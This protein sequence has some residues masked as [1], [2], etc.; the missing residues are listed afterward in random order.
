MPKRNLSSASEGFTEATD[1][2]PS[3]K[4]RNQAK[5]KGR[6][7]ENTSQGPITTPAIS[8]VESTPYISLA[9]PN[10]ANRDSTDDTSD[11][12]TNASTR[13]DEAREQEFEIGFIRTK[14][15]GIRHYDGMI[16]KKEKTVLVREPHNMYDR[17]A[18]RVDNAANEQVG[19][20]PRDVACH[21]SPLIDGGLMRAEGIVIGDRGVYGQALALAVVTTSANQ[22]RIRDAL[23]RSR[24][25]LVSAE[26]L[27][28]QKSAAALAEEEWQRILRQ[29]ESMTPEKSQQVLESLGLTTKDLSKLP[30]AP[31]PPGVVTKLLS[32]QKQ[33]LH[34]MINAEHPSPPHDKV[35]SQFWV[36]KN[37]AANGEHYLNLATGFATKTSPVL[38]RGG[39]LADDMGLGKTLQVISLIL[40]DPTG[41]GVVDVPTPL[42]TS[43]SKATLIVC[44]LSVVGNWTTQIETHVQTGQ[45]ATYVFHG[46][47]RNADPKFLADQDVVV[48]TYNM[49]AQS[50]VTSKKGLHAVK[51]RRVI[52][53]EGHIVRNR[54]SKQSEAA[55]KLDAE[56][57]FVVSGTPIQNSLADLYSIVK[58]LAFNPFDDYDWWNRCFARPV[59]IGD[60]EGIKRL[61]MLMQTICLRRTKNMQF[62]G[63]PIISLPT[64]TTY[65]YKID[66][67]HEDERKTYR[68]FQDE[69]ESRFRRY[70]ERDEV[71]E[72]YACI[73]E[74]LMRMR[75]C[76]NHLSLLGERRA[77]SIEEAK[78][79]ARSAALDLNN[80]NVQRL[81]KVLTENEGE[82]CA[83]C[84]DQLE[85]PVITPCAHFFCR[86]CIEQVIKTKP[87]CP[88]CRRDVPLQSLIEL[89][90]PP[91]PIEDDEDEVMETSEE[92][93]RKPGSSKIEAFLEILQASLHRDPIT[94]AVVFS[95]WTKMLDVVEPFLVDLK[96]PYVRFDGSMNRKKRERHIEE[97]QEN[98][99]CRVF[100]ASLKCA[101]FG[102]NLTAGNQVYLLDPWW[103]PSVEDQ[104][105]DRIYRLGQ[106]RP[107][108]V[109]RIVIRNTIEERVM[110]L[111]EKKRKLARKAFGEKKSTEEVRA[112][113]LEDLRALVGLPPVGKGAV[114]KEGDVKALGVAVEGSG[115][116][117]GPSAPIDLTVDGDVDVDLT[118]E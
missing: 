3:S 95:Q 63:K 82:D 110:Q 116:S 75:Q 20:I 61:K 81:L 28:L 10:A 8:V 57:R 108:S 39:I 69:L 36:K 7:D 74:L 44:P 70:E 85:T 15:V 35:P 106:T 78:Q 115:S 37:T 33:G 21:V 72:N 84:L 100:L 51:W 16:N 58:F 17:W 88:M 111:Q 6:S 118:G 1:T 18:I 62:N 26:D 38:T 112:T 53:D 14:I 30:E 102:L 90:P 55:F 92:V 42:D 24:L 80:E 4:R 50:S 12:S 56:R 5:G 96:I 97:F 22:E 107:V 2:S 45:L 19:H 27:K 93:V 25:S 60:S 41:G 52:L 32:Y 87:Q 40:S 109:F 13:E 99:G 113:R 101:G 114:K 91:A 43:Y 54:K 49:L 73:L 83:I 31:Q 94:K 46:A 105:V 11:T 34:W 98:E 23:K 47:D 79:I 67:K 9:N 104:A 71:M 64:C 48:T 76:C 86:K 77:M 65:L 103:N 117:G 89:P 59:R 29:T 68:A 66:F